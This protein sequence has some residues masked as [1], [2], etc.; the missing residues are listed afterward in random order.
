MKYIENVILMLRMRMNEGQKVK[1][2]VIKN[3]GQYYV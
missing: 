2:K 1:G 3:L